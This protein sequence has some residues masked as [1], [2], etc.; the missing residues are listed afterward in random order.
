MYDFWPKISRYSEVK[1]AKDHG[2]KFRS[3]LAASLAESFIQLVT[4]FFDVLQLQRHINADHLVGFYL[5]EESNATFTSKLI[6]KVKLS[7]G[8]QTM[9]SKY[10]YCTWFTGSNRPIKGR[11]E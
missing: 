1:T 10:Y 9:N 5:H 6:F 7:N 4:I 8:L 2:K 11:N 3:M